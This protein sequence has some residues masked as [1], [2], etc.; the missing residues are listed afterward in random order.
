MPRFP[1][2][3]ICIIR[4][5]A[6]GDVV[7]ALAI[8][9][10]L[11]KGYPSA[12]I[13]WITQ[14]VPGELIANHPSIDRIITFRRNMS[15]SQWFSFLKTLHRE[16]FDLLLVPQVSVKASLLAAA[17][18]S[19]IKIGYDIARARELSWLITN[20]RLPRHK[21]AHVLDQFLEFLFYLE[22]PLPEPMWNIQFSGS[23]LEWRKTWFSQFKHQ[24]AVFVPAS[25]K[26]EKDWSIEGYARVIDRVAKE[27]KLEC[28]IVGGP[29]K[30]EKKI[31]EE[32]LARTESSPVL[33]L[34][35]PIRNTLLQLSG[36]RVVIAPDTG[37]LHM[38]VALGVPVIGLYGFSNPNR[39]GPY[40]FRELLIDKFNDPDKIPEPITRKTKLD[41]MNK[42]NADEVFEKILLA[43]KIPWK[44]DYPLK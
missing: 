1:A 20:K 41:R 15:L 33:A 39:C 25:S 28:A 23:E 36:A 17:I 14:Q 35:K 13:T 19:P 18:R 43:L 32:I 6:L 22:I 21:P 34:E 31:A 16:R 24:V 10:G 8:A 3:E 29:G 12:K 27:T 4:T 44:P 11:R 37:P 40:R 26:T 7:N 9:N 38:A 30:R 2:N 42:I 5:S